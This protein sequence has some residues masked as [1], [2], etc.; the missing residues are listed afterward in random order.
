MHIH[1]YQ[2]KELFSSFG[3]PTTKSVLINNEEEIDSALEGD[4][5]FPLV[6]KA[7]IHAGGRGKGHFLEGLQGGV[8]IAQTI[9]E[10]K[11]YVAQMLGNTLVTQQTGAEGKK[12]HHIL[13]TESVSIQKEYYLAFLMDREHAQPVLV[14]SSEGGVNIEELAQTQ[15]EKL[16]R[17]RI[18]SLGGL[19]KYQ[20]G[21]LFS[22]LKLPS[23]ARKDFTAILQGLYT[24]F[25]QKDASMIEINPLVLTTDEKIIP[26]DAK[27]SFDD[28]AL[29][30][31]ADIAAY[32]DPS[33]S[34]P[35]ELEASQYGLNYIGLEGNI[36]CLVN[37]AG[38]AMA[39]MDIIKH[40]GASPANFLDVGGGATKEQVAA[41][42]SIIL[43]DP[44][45]KAILVNIFGGIMQCDVIAQGIIDATAQLELTLPLI[46]RL[47]GTNV[48]E[49]KKILQES[50]L[51]IITADSLDE[52][53]Q[54][55]V[56]A[57]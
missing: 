57:I 35:R 32:R 27:C 54:K 24:L 1:E 28:N 38:L 51:P 25:I 15:P 4:F 55:A 52:A 12:V 22:F 29:Y 2:A 40:Y 46:I 43:S 13:L 26:L 18:S 53:A 41:A 6:V 56:A 19:Q 23:G 30:R 48:K 7:Q 14:A 17:E 21:K 44:K 10:V 36:A 9:E 42:F 37:G 49:G 39:T 50:G 31:H 20:I 33:E 3:V 47:E 11:S 5:N 8:H 34:D 16:C 45:V